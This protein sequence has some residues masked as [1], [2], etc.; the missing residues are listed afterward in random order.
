MPGFQKDP[1]TMPDQEGNQWARTGGL[2]GRNRVASAP[3]AAKQAPAANANP[4]Q[5]IVNPLATAGMNLKSKM[6]QNPFANKMANEDSG[7]LTQGLAVNG[8]VLGMIGGLA[9]DLKHNTTRNALSD[10]GQYVPRWLQATRESTGGV[11]PSRVRSFVENTFGHLR[12]SGPPSA[13][14]ALSN[15]TGPDPLARVAKQDWK[16]LLHHPGAAAYNNATNIRMARHGNKL[17][18]LLGLKSLLTTLKTGKPFLG[19]ALGVGAGLAGGYAAE[20]N[21]YRMSPFMLPYKEKASQAD[22]G[23][24]S[25]N[26]NPLQPPPAPPQPAPAAP[27]MYPPGQGPVTSQVPDQSQM[28]IMPSPAMPAP[29]QADQIGAFPPMQVQASVAGYMENVSDR[30]LSELFGP[31]GPSMRAADQHYGSAHHTGLSSSLG[32]RGTFQS[33]G[34][35]SGYLQSAQSDPHGHT[36]RILRAHVVSDLGSSNGFDHIAGLH[37]SHIPGTLDH[38]GVQKLGSLRATGSVGGVLGIPGN[39]TR[40]SAD[41]T[42]KSASHQ[43]IA[44]RATG[45][46]YQADSRVAPGDRTA[47]RNYLAFGQGERQLHDKAA[48]VRSLLTQRRQSIKLGSDG[49][50][51]G[52]YAKGFEASPRWV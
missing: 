48:T 46:Q 2:F 40:S 31:N 52:S 24:G 34:K 43:R 17:N 32:N 45:N 21:G 26:L 47:G 3:T 6:V 27:A 1:M 15:V 12:S 41:Q 22:S 4:Y 50:S 5:Q 39:R 18:K 7:R 28:Q 35:L 44:N 30:S 29:G 51:E 13:S 11:N 19:A 25:M 49:R 33:Q 20:S 36:D 16:P 8:G 10:F 23:P 38:A 14:R 42:Q 9:H 37:N